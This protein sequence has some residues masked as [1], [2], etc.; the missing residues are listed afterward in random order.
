M[1]YFHSPVIWCWQLGNEWQKSLSKIRNHFTFRS[2]FFVLI[3]SVF[4]L[5]FSMQTSASNKQYFVAIQRVVLCH[6]HM[7]SIFKWN[8]RKTTISSD[9]FNEYIIICGTKLYFLF[10][11]CATVQFS[12]H[13]FYLSLHFTI[14]NG[15]QKTK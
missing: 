15:K 9:I 8:N 12:L 14:R 7:T 5:N 13:V 6:S 2:R 10:L 3:F 11:L 4:P 1:I